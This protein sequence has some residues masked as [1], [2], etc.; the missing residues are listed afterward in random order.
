[1]SWQQAEHALA[2]HGSTAPANGME[3]STGMDGSGEP[4]RDT[5]VT[6]SS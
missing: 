2:V 5:A 4:E 1:M 3:G 6:C